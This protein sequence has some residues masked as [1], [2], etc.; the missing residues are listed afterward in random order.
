VSSRYALF[1]ALAIKKQASAAACARL[2]GISTEESAAVLRAAAATGRAVERDGSY[3]LTPLARI[4]LES[5]YS[6]SFDTLRGDA[7][8]ISAYERFE[9][10][11]IELKT[12]ITEWQTIDSGGTRLPNDHTDRDYD[13][14]IIDRLG[15]LHERADQILQTLQK[16]LPRFRYYQDNLQHALEQAEQGAVEWVSGPRI[17]SYHTLWFELHEDLLRILGR[18]R[19]EQ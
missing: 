14:A 18:R 4:A 8:F 5:D 7:A 3:M 19:S 2:A 13:L 15:E 11:N 9:R 10:I 1:H 12:L 6:R 17:E 16:A